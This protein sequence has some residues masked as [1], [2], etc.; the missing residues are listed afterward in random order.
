M[1]PQI[2]SIE[3]KRKTGEAK[4]KELRS[5]AAKADENKYSIL[6]RDIERLESELETVPTYPQI[7]ASDVTPEQLAV[8]MATNEEGMAILSDE[9]CIFDILG[10]LYS[11][12]KANIDLFLQAHSVSPVRVDRGSRPPVFMQRPVLSMGLT[13]Q[14]EVVKNICRNK[15]FRGRGL[16]GRCLYVLPISN[17]GKRNFSEPPMAPEVVQNYRAALRSI[18]NHPDKV[19]DN[20]KTQY[21]LTLE[22]AAYEKWLDYAKAVEK[23]M[24]E[25]I[26]HL[27][28]ITDWAGK[29]PGAIARIAALL[30]IMRHSHCFPWQHPIS[31]E[32]MAAAVKIGHVLTNHALRVFDLLQLG[33]S[34]QLAFDIYK[35]IK[36]EKPACITRRDCSRKFRRADKEELK[37]ALDILEDKD[38]IRERESIQG[39][40]G[41]KK[42][43]FDVPPDFFNNK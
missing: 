38:I 41:R 32:D 8:I 15:T 14:P 1:E 18:L 4:L 39:K 28:H 34:Q 23:L 24:G 31:L 21:V 5:T 22:P 27:S 30:H 37:S 26:G 6:Q 17:I 13:I 16:L 35:W 42:N 29:L 11:D 33:S 19:V 43:I 7:W 9:G 3:S 25:E 2:K 12:G 40:S 10:G 36:D 20:V